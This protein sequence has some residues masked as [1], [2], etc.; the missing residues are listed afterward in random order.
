MKYFVK[1]GGKVYGP[2]DEHKIEEKVASGFFSKNL[3][4]STD[5]EEWAPPVFSGEEDLETP[6]EI[7]PKVEWYDWNAKYSDD[8]GT[9][10][11]F[12]AEDPASAA[13]AERTEERFWP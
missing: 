2:V 1:S 9:D 3:L 10:Y 5:R 6:I 11:V 8:S 13:L 4:V 7:R 12:P